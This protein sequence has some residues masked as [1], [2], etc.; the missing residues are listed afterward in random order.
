MICL[1]LVLDPR[2]KLSF[3]KKNWPEDK[4]AE[5]ENSITVLW[6]VMYKP[7]SNNETENDQVAPGHSI[8]D[9]LW[10]IYDIDNNNVRSLPSPFSNE[11]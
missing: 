2:I 3:F 5:L 1:F 4:S 9:Q 8:I 11:I 6:E 7:M 10:A